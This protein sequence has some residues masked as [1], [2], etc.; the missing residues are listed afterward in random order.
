[1]ILR[2]KA[3]KWPQGAT[4]LDLVKVASVCLFLSACAGAPD[5]ALKPN[6]VIRGV[7]SGTRQV[8]DDYYSVEPD[9]SNPGYP[10]IKVIGMPAHGSVA[11]DNGETY[12]NFPK[13]NVRY[14]CNKKKIASSRLLYE[15]IPGFHGKDSFTVQV[16]FVKSNL[17]LITYSINVL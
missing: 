14:E 5:A 8:I 13:D 10:E 12:P 17:R 3:I 16:R 2:G 11:V 4:M 1:M 6:T 9:C 15:S 7:D